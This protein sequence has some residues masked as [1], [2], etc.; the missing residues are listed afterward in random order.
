MLVFFKVL[1]DDHCL[2]IQ[3]FVVVAVHHNWSQNGA[4][5]VEQK[6]MEKIKSLSNINKKIPGN[7]F[8]G[9]LYLHK[10]PHTTALFSQQNVKLTWKKDMKFWSIAT[11]YY[12]W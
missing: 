2:Q 7:S 10:T 6:N 12:Y 5:A 4:S 1:K 3:K 11:L 8:Q 9:T